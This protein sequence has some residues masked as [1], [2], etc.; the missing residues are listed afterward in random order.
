MPFFNRRQMGLCFSK[1]FRAEAKGRKSGWDCMEMLKETP[2]CHTDRRTR[3]FCRKQ[4]AKFL[5]SF[6]EGP[7][8]GIY[9]FAGGH[10]TYIPQDVKRYVLKTYDVKKESAKR[11]SRSKSRSK[12]RS[13]KTKS[14]KIKRS[15]K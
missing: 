9:F 11:R 8:G 14:S 6:R 2:K 4:S 10:K 15:S 13:R 3:H 5:T 7:N 12:S 1:H